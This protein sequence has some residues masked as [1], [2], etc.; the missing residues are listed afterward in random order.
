MF[1]LV[2]GDE[3]AKA[4]INALYRDAGL[5]GAERHAREIAASTHARVELRSL[6]DSP[7]VQTAA[8]PGGSAAANTGDVPELPRLFVAFG[9]VFPRCRPADLIEAHETSRSISA[10]LTCWGD[11]TLNL[12]RASPQAVQ[13]ALAGHISSIQISRLLDLRAKHPTV[14]SSDLLDA[15]KLTEKSRDVLDGLL[16]NDSSCHSLWIVSR[17]ADR[18][19]YDLAVSDESAGDSSPSQ[20]VQ[21]LVFSW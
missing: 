1:S 14:E 9:Q 20:S 10:S 19:W 2:F 16:V 5:A 3:Q 12:H 4:N 13:A 7:D 18:N 15:L 8:I 21:T 17:L 11:G 6:P